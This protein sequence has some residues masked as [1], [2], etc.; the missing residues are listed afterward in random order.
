MRERSAR[1][2]KRRFLKEQTSH[3]LTLEATH[4]CMIHLA[5]V[6]RDGGMPEDAWFSLVSK[7]VVLTADYRFDQELVELYF[8]GH[9]R[10]WKRVARKYRDLK[11]RICDTPEMLELDAE[12]CAA[13]DRYTAD[14]FGCYGFRDLGEL[15]LQAREEFEAR[16]KR[17]SEF[18]GADR[19]H[20][21]TSGYCLCPGSDP[22]EPP[23]TIGGVTE[24]PDLLPEL[25]P[26][27][28]AF[29]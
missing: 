6:M 29:A 21:G 16:K 5:R 23:R 1:Y 2:W 7:A 10:R 24:L 15:Y 14:L 22:G 25:A 3:L 28:M 8:A 18:L 4:E 26:S 19:H 9:K 13:M 11:E 27:A 17:S 12:F 20:F